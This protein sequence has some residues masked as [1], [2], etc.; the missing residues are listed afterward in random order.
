MLPAGFPFFKVYIPLCLFMAIA[1]C[2]RM[3]F[4]ILKQSLIMGHVFLFD[5]FR[6]SISHKALAFLDLWYFVLYLIC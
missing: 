4:K 6:C 3:L 2:V 5:L 1:F